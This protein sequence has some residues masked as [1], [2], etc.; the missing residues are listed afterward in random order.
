[1]NSQTQCERDA[2]TPDL[3]EFNVT[4]AVIERMPKAAIFTAHE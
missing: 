1:M 3:E 4:D 2:I